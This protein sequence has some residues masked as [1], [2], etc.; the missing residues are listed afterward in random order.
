MLELKSII[1]NTL[2]IPGQSV[3]SQCWNIFKVYTLQMYSKRSVKHYKPNLKSSINPLIIP[4][5]LESSGTLVFSR[6]IGAHSLNSN[7]TT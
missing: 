2:N 6:A 1:L 4:D 5:W 7:T 3:A